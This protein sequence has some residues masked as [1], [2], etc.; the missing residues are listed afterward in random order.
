[1]GNEKPYV[2]N[3][4]VTCGRRKEYIA[5]HGKYLLKKT[6]TIKFYFNLLLTQ[7]D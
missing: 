6:A 2:I 3:L 4:S 7:S 1:M 5:I